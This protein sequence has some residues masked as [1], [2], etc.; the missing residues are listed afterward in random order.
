MFIKERLVTLSNNIKSTVNDLDSDSLW[1]KLTLATNWNRSNDYCA[2]RQIGKLVEIRFMVTPKTNF[3][4]SSSDL[5]LA[6]GLPENCQPATW[7]V[8]GVAFHN[9]N[10]YRIEIPIKTNANGGKIYIARNAN[11]LSSEYLITGQIMFI[12]GVLLNILNMLSSR[13]EVGIC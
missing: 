10:S 2:Y 6:Y 12:R 13:M 9:G 5:L 4:A 1:S 11:G 3:P 8:K 7:G